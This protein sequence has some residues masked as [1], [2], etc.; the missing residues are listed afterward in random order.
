MCCQPSMSSKRSLK[1]TRPGHREKS[2]STTS[3]NWKGKQHE[4]YWIGSDDNSYVSL[5]G[6]T[7][8]SYTLAQTKMI[9]TFT[10]KN[11]SHLHGIG[12]TPKRP[13]M[14]VPLFAGSGGG[15]SSKCDYLALS[16]GQLGK[17]R[18]MCNTIK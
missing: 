3:T 17:C 6:I 12:T 2:F 8:E 16:L 15:L 5:P 4:I 9:C 11:M 14:K 18:Y 10:R 7:F 1:K 13:N